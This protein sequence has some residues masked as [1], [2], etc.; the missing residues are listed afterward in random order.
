MAKQLECIHELFYK[1]CGLC[2]KKSKKQIID[3]LKAQHK[4][5][6]IEFDFQEFNEEELE[7][8]DVDY[9][10]EFDES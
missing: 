6:G 5:K 4:E 9:D 7:E 3:E 8:Q 2:S 10:I 1:T